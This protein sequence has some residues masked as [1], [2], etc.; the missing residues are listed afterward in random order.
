MGKRLVIPINFTD[1]DDYE[2]VKNQINASHYIR[3]LVKK[4]REGKQ[5]ETDYIDRK[6]EELKKEL[7][8]NS[9]YTVLDEKVDKKSIKD[10]NLK[11]NVKNMFD[12]FN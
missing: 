8:N 4:D 7:K 11:E 9:I 2:Y 3:E 12:M 5:V 1:K 10:E 6:I